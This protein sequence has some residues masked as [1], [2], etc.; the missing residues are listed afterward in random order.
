MRRRLH[1]PLGG[2]FRRASTLTSD[3]GRQF[4]STLWQHVCRQLGVQHI[5]TTAHHP[6]VNGMVERSHRQL[7]DALK[8]RLACAAWLDHLPW[9][10]LGLRVAPK[11]DTAISSAELVYL[12]PL[13]LPAQ[14]AANLETPIAALIEK[15][16]AV[17]PI[18]VR[19]SQLPTP[20]APPIALRTAQPCRPSRRRMQ[21]PT[22]SSAGGR[23]SSRW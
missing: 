19:H 15:L 5:N 10:L 4:T 1:R 12:A 2:T 16:R 7:K 14:L 8:A 18:P 22:E 3:Q 13:V 11:E 9:V 23:S 21:A 6:Q 17:T 20:T